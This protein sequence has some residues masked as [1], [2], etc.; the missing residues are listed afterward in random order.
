M[1]TYF[2]PPGNLLPTPR[3]LISYPQGTYFL[4][5]RTSGLY[6]VQKQS[7]E[8]LELYPFLAVTDDIADAM[9]YLRYDIR[10]AYEID[11]LIF[12]SQIYHT[13]EASISCGPAVYHI[14]REIY[15]FPSREGFS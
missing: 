12:A 4:P 7:A 6:A 9:I 11:N 8:A 14:S 13:C 1:G 15:H 5:L 3:E 2:L 10:C